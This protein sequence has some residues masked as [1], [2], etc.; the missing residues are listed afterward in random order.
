MIRKLRKVNWAYALGEVFLIVVGVNLALFFNNLNENRKI[1]KIEIETL[2][3]I[4]E[5][6]KAD[7]E[8]IKSNIE[9]FSMRTKSFGRLI[10]HLDNKIPVDDS[11]RAALTWLSGSTMFIANRTPYE[12]LKSRGFNLISNDSLRTA[13]MKYYDVSQDWIVMNEGQYLD[14]YMN[15][16]KP[17]LIK[18]FAFEKGMMPYDFKALSNNRE[19]IQNLRWANSTNYFQL[20]LYKE[21][22]IEAQ[23]LI[24]QI[25]T[26]L[27]S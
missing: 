6:L 18:H 27:G 10:K 19:V 26:E 2:H 7:L 12:T 22:E 23:A 24:Q 8:D 14:H 9:G 13:I 15:H 11:L 21:I 5:G 16:I 1:K 20:K 17:I 25:D 3:E 4:K